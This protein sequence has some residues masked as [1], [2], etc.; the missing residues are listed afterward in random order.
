M[1]TSLRWLIE[2][3]LQGIDS[4]V[5]WIRF[6]LHLERC[7]DR[8]LEALELARV[9][10]DH[11][12]DLPIIRLICIVNHGPPIINGVL[13]QEDFEYRQFLTSYCSRD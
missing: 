5:S 13:A 1:H 11:L 3:Y 6:F 2:S 10:F 4:S 9:G 7:S 8:L 12:D